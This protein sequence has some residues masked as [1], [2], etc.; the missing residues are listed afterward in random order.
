MGNQD[1]LVKMM[2][3]VHIRGFSGIIVMYGFCCSNALLLSKSLIL[4]TIIIL[5]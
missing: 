2:A 5:D 4:N 1:F 3:V